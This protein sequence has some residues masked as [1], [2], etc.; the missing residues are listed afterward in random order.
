MPK[1]DG[2]SS[3]FD[4]CARLETVDMS[5][6]KMQ[7]CSTMTSLF[8]NCNNLKSVDFSGCATTQLDNMSRMFEDCSNLTDVNLDGMDTSKVT[9]MEGMFNNCSSLESI[10]LSSLDWSSLKWDKYYIP[11]MFE[12]CSN[13]KIVKLPKIHKEL[14]MVSLFGTPSFEEQETVWKGSDGKTYSS[15]DVIPAAD[16][17]SITL[18]RIQ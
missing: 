3:M 1:L 16:G 11:A 7:N 15:S 17:K 10:D 6:C 2:L 9:S 4:G 5:N 14:T 8:S 13:L 18:T 12:G